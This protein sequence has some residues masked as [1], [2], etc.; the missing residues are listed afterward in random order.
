M[1][2]FFRNTAV[3]AFGFGMAMTFTACHSGDSAEEPQ[4]PA[5]K[6][7]SNTVV[8]NRM[9]LV[10][11]NVAATV[12]YNNA[13]P[14]AKSGTL[15][16]FNGAAQSGSLTVSATGYKSQ[17]VSVAFGENTAKL[18]N[19]Q[20]VKAA[21][22]GQAKVAGQSVSVSNE[23]QN[24]R[25][26]A[27]DGTDVVATI[28]VPEDVTVDAD[29]ANDKFSIVVFTP[30][31]GDAQDVEK[32]GDQIA[33][34]VLAVDCEPDGAK[35][36]KPVTV[37]VN[38]PGSSKLD[39]RLKHKA[40]G[41]VKT[42]GNGLTREG[43]KIK[44]T[45]EHFSQWDYELIANAEEVVTEEKLI[46]SEDKVVNAG[47]QRVSFTQWIGY[48][49]NNAPASLIGK[50]LKN[51]YSTVAREIRNSF[52]YTAAEKS[53]AHIEVYQK[54]KNIVFKS[55]EETFKVLSYGTISHKVMLTPTEEPVPVHSGGSSL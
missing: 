1:K 24:Q 14:S 45:I 41:E 3:L 13:N 15:Y 9:L 11:T 36:D 10:Q 12:K 48:D 2:K 27:I 7:A 28:D 17:T 51:T 50:F 31:S 54:V 35:F 20:L 16:T 4:A 46:Y 34:A 39:L 5:A 47:Q 38:I 43:D 55:G 29:H 37:T 25:D 44:A 26:N 19:V 23:D 42:I 8:S 49:A 6:D 52:T 21:T 32:K 18:V 40:S 53:Q 30:A 22:N 33:E